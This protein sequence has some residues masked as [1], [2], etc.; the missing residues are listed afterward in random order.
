[1]ER[2][3][4]ELSVV[5]NCITV[6]VPLSKSDRD[7]TDS[8]GTIAGGSGKRLRLGTGLFATLQR[9]NGTLHV[10]SSRG[11]TIAFGHEIDRRAVFG[12]SWLKSASNDLA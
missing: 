9:V 6:I 10:D 8:W 1:M 11:Q 12:P 7:S 3:T 5:H 2:R 4:L